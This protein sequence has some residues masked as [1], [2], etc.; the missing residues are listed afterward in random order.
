MHVFNEIYLR[1]EYGWN[2]SSPPRVIV[3]AGAYT[4]LST[5]FFASRFPDAIIIAVEP[6]QEN[7]ELLVQNTKRY[8]NVHPIRAALWSESGNV[9]LV[10]PGDGAWG[11]RLLESDDSSAATAG[12]NSAFGSVRA[13]TVTD[14][15]RDYD[16]EKIDLLKV[17]VEGSEREIFANPDPWIASVGA[18]CMELH[19]RFK[20]GCS[21]SF[22]KAVSDFPI[23]LRRG[24]DVLVVRDRSFLNPVL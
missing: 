18:I 13:I 24:E 11:L 14:I 16:L 19:D 5:S 10:D 9:S 17:D 15:I 6:D 1:Q 22:F 4:G 8:T 3:D 21:R 12:H 23:E 2:F 7:F 20:A